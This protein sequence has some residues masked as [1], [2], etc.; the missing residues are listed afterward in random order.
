MQ[1]NNLNTKFLGKK[2]YYYNII[3]STQKEVW[4]LYKQNAPSGTLVMAGIQT[5]GIGTHGRIWHTDKENNIAFSF[6]ITTD[7]NVKK[8]EGITLKTAQ[9]VLE[10]FKEK[11]GISLEIKEPNDIVYNNRKIGGILTE[12]KVS[13]ENVKAI[14]IGIGINTSQTIFDK[15]IQEIATSIKKEFGINIDIEIFIEKFCEKFEKEILERI[16]N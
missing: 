12:T 6:L 4:R 14:V 16:E 9:I 5:N 10:V 1:L 15:S 13:L 3:D 7:T 8:L 11:Y 2:I